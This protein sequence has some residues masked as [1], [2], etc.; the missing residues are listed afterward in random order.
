M[1]SP[2][3]IPTYARRLAA[4]DRRQQIILA[5]IDV[6]AKRGF[7]GATTK[8]IAEAAGVS[9][10]IIFRHFATKQD[11]YAAILDFKTHETERQGWI[12]E[13]RELSLR[14]DDEKFFGL[15]VTKMLEA[16][17]RDPLFHR[18]MVYAALE[19]QE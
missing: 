8:Q 11:L 1:K 6:F 16:H 3:V 14:N 7:Q 19:G 12:E 15:I 17:L 9:E 4:G 13:L 5:A 10:A 2:A 18:L